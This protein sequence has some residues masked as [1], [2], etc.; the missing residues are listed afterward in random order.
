[1]ASPE[2]A[3]QEHEQ[4]SPETAPIELTHDERLVLAALE[5]AGRPMDTIAVASATSL[6]VEQ[7]HE[8]LRGL[9]TRGVI[10]EQPPEPVRERFR[11]D[12]GALQRV[13]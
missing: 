2:R 4:V 7:S 8:I 10:M 1:M 5:N 13:G 12:E 11:V 6:S 3:N 9:T